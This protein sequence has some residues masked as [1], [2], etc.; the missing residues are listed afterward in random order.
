MC[1]V[2][3][4]SGA[5]PT[6]VQ[7]YENMIQLLPLIIQVS[8]MCYFFHPTNC[9]MLLLFHYLRNWKMYKKSLLRIKRLIFLNIFC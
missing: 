7:L 3:N 9:N 8:V 2:H 4:D 6:D 1:L 5:L